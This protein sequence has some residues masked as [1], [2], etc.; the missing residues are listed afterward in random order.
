MKLAPAAVGP[1]CRWPR[2]QLAPVPVGP[3]AGCSWPRANTRDRLQLAPVAVGP[4]CSWPWLQ[5]APVAAGPAAGC[6]WP[7]LRLAPVAV[8]PGAG[9]SRPRLQS[10]PAAVGPAAGRSW[11]RLPVPAGA[12][13]GPCNQ[14]CPSCQARCLLWWFLIPADLGRAIYMARSQF[15][16]GPPLELPIINCRVYYSGDVA[17]DVT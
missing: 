2:L 13:T 10:A 7:R 9:Y 14:A 6:S 17:V 8:G 12:A 5:L 4:G 11:P 3:P 16:P 1:G 15:K